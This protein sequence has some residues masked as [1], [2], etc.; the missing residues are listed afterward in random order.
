[1]EIDDYDALGAEFGNE[2]L[3]KL[4]KEVFAEFIDLAGDSETYL[5]KSA[6]EVRI[7]EGL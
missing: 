1:L 3:Q 2:T 5:M 7:V 6:E 4:N